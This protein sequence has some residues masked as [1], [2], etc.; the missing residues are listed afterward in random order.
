M[1]TFYNNNLVPGVCYQVIGHG[2]P[3][4]IALVLGYGNKN[5]VWELCL[6]LSSS[7]DNRRRLLSVEQ[8]AV[9]YH[10]NNKNLSK[11]PL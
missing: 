9:G 2:T 7:I 1:I 11:F 6:S 8:M 5:Y 10:K 3:F 4:V